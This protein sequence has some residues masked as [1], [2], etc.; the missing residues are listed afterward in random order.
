[1]P[2]HRHQ[3]FT[4]PKGP[5]GKTISLG[6]RPST[7]VTSSQKLSLARA[8]N[9]DTAEL[10]RQTSQCTLIRRH[11]PVAQMDRALPSE[12][13]GREFESLR[14]HQFLDLGLHAAPTE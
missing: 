10:M 6:K 11:A 3:R 5:D 12:G 2:W 14:A 7:L 1:M 4:G 13:R 8:S 9:A